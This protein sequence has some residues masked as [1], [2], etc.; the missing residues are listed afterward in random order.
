MSE[1]SRPKLVMRRRQQFDI[2]W[3]KL[4]QFLSSVIYTYFF[5][6]KIIVVDVRRTILQKLITNP[7]VSVM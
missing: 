2:S 1:C 3:R 5:L 7:R 4:S 6:K